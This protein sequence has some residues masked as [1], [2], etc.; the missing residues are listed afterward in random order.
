MLEHS[1]LYPLNTLT[2]TSMR[3]DGMWRFQIDWDEKGDDEKWQDGIPGD[4]MI[5]VPASFQDFYTDKRVREFTGDIW[6]ESTVFI[7]SGMKGSDVFLR[8]RYSSARYR[9]SW[10]CNSGRLPYP[11]PDP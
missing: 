1:L 8:S 9:K 2:R 4:E 11:N 3:L 7:P 6:Y 5:P 10:S